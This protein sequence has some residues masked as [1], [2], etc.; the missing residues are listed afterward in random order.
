MLQVDLG[1]NPALVVNGV[2]HP[3]ALHPEPP[4]T[5]LVRLPVSSRELQ[6][7]AT[8]THKASIKPGLKT[9][10]KVAQSLRENRE[11]A[12]KE[13]EGKRAVLLDTAPGSRSS[14]HTRSTS[15]NRHLSPAGSVPSRTSSPVPS[16]SAAHASRPPSRLSAVPPKLPVKPPTSSFHIGTGRV[17]TTLPVSRSSSGSG[18]A[19]ASPPQSSAAVA[20]P[21]TS[22]T[23][24]AASPPHPSAEL[25]LPVPQLHVPSRQSSSSSTTSISSTASTLLAKTAE[26]HSLSSGTSVTS[27]ESLPLPIPSEGGANVTTPQEKA[28]AKPPEEPKKPVRAGGGGLLKGKESLKKEKRK[29]ER[30][31]ERG[32]S[33][34]G[35]AAPSPRGKAADLPPA[36]KAAKAKRVE[37]EDASTDAE[38][39]RS[40]SAKAK[41]KG[42]ADEPLARKDDEH[43]AKKRKLAARS[44]GTDSD[45]GS[46]SERPKPKKAITTTLVKRTSGSAAASSRERESEAAS[47]SHGATPGSKERNKRRER[48]EAGRSPTAAS[49]AHKK[50]KQKREKPER[51]YSSSSGD[52]AEADPRARSAV[53]KDAEKLKPTDSRS[54][55]R[56]SLKPHPSP[57]ASSALLPNGHAKPIPGSPLR[58]STS[59][60]SHQ[61][62]PH[63]SPRPLTS[64]SSLP[65]IAISIPPHPPVPVDSSTAFV[66]AKLR[67][68]ELY[69]SYAALHSQLAEERFRLERGEPPHLAKDEGREKVERCGRMRAQLEAVKEGMTQ[70]KAEQVKQG[71]AK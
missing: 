68:L 35:T 53:G 66:A 16:A 41:G 2:S 71:R 63:A 50:K 43:D 46:A 11:L 19:A 13:R 57:S 44:S 36:A 62:P 14:S 28:E 49:G 17:P 37:G 25:A 26:G 15:A 30:A 55:S 47:S 64:A 18:S 12:E 61:P 69:A 38:G 22:N 58:K 7:I 1:A 6:P 5:E 8:L 54:P 20:A 33:A 65:A 4:H 40:A 34:A 59:I 51:W 45:A 24:S 21:S 9:L 31:R 23:A 70:W 32:T 42:K 60:A 10:D 67:F 48:E 3:L 27:P 52:D 56:D 29:E 39:R